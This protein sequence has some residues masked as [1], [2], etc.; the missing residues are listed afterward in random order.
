M[1]KKGSFVSRVYLSNILN[2]TVLVFLLFA[3]VHFFPG[4]AC[5]QDVTVSYQE[6]YD[7]LSPYGQWIEDSANGYVWVPN[8]DGEF[9]PYWTDG[10][11]AMTEYGNTWVSDYAWGWACFHYG[12]WIYNDFYGWVWV[13][14]YEWGPGWVAWRWGDGYC[15]WA[16]LYPG[17][18]WELGM[19]YSCPEDWWIFMHPRH[20]HRDHYL[21]IWRG[22]F[23]HG[24]LYKHTLIER[25][26]IVRNTVAVNNRSYVSGPRPAEIEAV[27]HRPVQVYH[28]SYASQRGADRVSGSAVNIYKPSRFEPA[29]A[30][31]SRPRPANVMRAPAPVQINRPQPMSTR[32]DEP[33]PFNQNMQRQS[34]AWS[35]PRTSPAPVQQYNRQQQPMRAPSFAPRN[36]AP[37]RSAPARAPSSGGRR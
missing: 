24:P 18:A 30:G 4:K 7:A 36:T 1:R 12:R 9:Q 14:G 22:Y 33:R 13:P 20:L 32:Q 8:V 21:N 10:Y 2:R 34:P 5:A 25:T 19:A 15:G 16:P 28:L 37:V 29:P 27:T 17:F 26:T 35:H 3:S 31:G 23:F 11:W 6:F